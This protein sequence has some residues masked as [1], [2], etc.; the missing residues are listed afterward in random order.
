MRRILLIV[1]AIA[2]VVAI[3]VVWL[4]PATLVGSRLESATGGA[5]RLA[6]TEGTIWHARGMLVT[7]RARLPI[8]WDLAFWPLLRGEARVRI[9]PYAGTTH[10]P[11]R[12]VLTLR[13]DSVAVRDAE[14]VVPASMLATLAAVPP[15]WIA[16]GD[17]SVVATAIEWAPPASRGEVRITWQRA[18]LT[19]PWGGNAVELGAVTAILTA[20]GDAI[21]GPVRTE[22]GELDVQGQVAFRAGDATTIAL[23]VIPRGST[24]PALASALQM[25][26]A[27]DGAGWRID[28][29]IPAR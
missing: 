10:G 24:D 23:R 2:V 20:Q 1:A 14:L 17:F 13:S 7:E 15:A 18:R 8:A 12:A 3:E 21:G 4:A 6:D 27:E 25:L 22:G 29:R 11:P 26:G 28:W 19:P 9:A 5:L 16:G